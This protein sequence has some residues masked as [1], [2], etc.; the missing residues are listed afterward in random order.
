MSIVQITAA[1]VIRSREPFIEP[2]VVKP[3]KRA[4]ERIRRPRKKQTSSRVKAWLK[5]PE[6]LVWLEAKITEKDKQKKIRRRNFDIAAM[7]QAGL[8]YDCSKCLHGIGHHCEE[9][10]PDGC[11]D[12]LEVE[13]AA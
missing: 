10:L 9:D 1:E 12:Y 11:M 5:T 2:Q 8:H 7:K 3:A 13:G 4:T 6:G